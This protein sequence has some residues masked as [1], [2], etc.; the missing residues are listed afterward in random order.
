MS[1]IVQEKDKYFSIRTANTEYQM[2]ADKFGVLKHLWYGGPTRT[3]MEYLLDYPD[4]GFSGNIYDVGKVKTY[5][6][7]TLPQE[8]SCYGTGDYR[9]A[10]LSV[11]HPHGGRAVDLRYEGYAVRKGKYSIPGLP[12][13]YGENAETLE[14]ILRDTQLGLK[15]I[16]RYGVFEDLDI[17]ARST[18]IVN[19]GSAPVIL[20]KAASLC[21]DFT[22]GSW[23]WVHFAGRHVMERTPQRAPLVYGIQE[24]SSIRGAS[25]HQQNPSVILCDP[26]CTEKSGD[27]FGAMLLY[28]GSFQTQVQ[29]DQLG[30]VR[31]VMGLNPDQFSWKLVPGES[32]HTPEAVFSSSSNGFEK[33][34]HNFH[35]LVRENITRGKYKDAP[36]PVLINSWEA[37]YFEF[38]EEQLIG[39]AEEAAKLGI[40]MFV[41]DDGWFGKRDD[42]FAGLGD[43]TTVNRKKLP[44][45]LDGFV[46]RIKKLGMSFGLWFEPEMVSE[47]SDLY[48]AHPDW[49]LKLPGRNPVRCRYQL[50]LDLSRKEVEDYLFN[51]ISQVLNSADISYVKWDMNRSLF[52]WYSPELEPEQMGELPHRYILGL[53]SLLERL[54]SAFPDVLF[55]GCSGGGGRFDA[56]MLYYC[57][58]IWCSDNTDAYER[59]IIQYGTSFFYPPST[60]ASHVSAVPNHQSGRVTPIAARTVVATAGSFGYE[61]NPCK[62]SDDEKENVRA[63]IRSYK[64]RQPLVFDGD[65]YRLSNPLKEDMAVWEFVS[66]DQKLALLQGVVYRTK[67]NTL[68]RVR[69]LRGLDPEKT[70]F[71]EGYGITCTGAALMKGGILLPENWGDYCAVEIVIREAE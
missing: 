58:Q 35:R 8:Y 52:D 43:W 47:D 65:Y 11:R 71:V 12:A 32:F 68:R 34:S 54:T 48:R 29:L 10:S 66:K 33:L 20:E 22:C 16:L 3:N 46:E 64:E 1:I 2:A 51:A 27:C 21:L 36:R 5:S 18:E 53:Y 70:Y 15:A 14:I 17:I 45:G 9:L 62:L 61:L 56:G 69:K 57:P 55:E 4:V 42:D 19:E 50:I 31:I 40:D 23:E 63:Q 41:L 44:S 49:A 24:S 28:S 39:F 59:S 7:D 60:M 38:E 67:S 25:S 13:S 37:A 26:D 6:L 30:Q